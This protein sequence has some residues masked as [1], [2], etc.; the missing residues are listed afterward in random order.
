VAPATANILAK[1]ARI[2]QQAKEL[3]SEILEIVHGKL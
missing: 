3:E 1:A 2:E